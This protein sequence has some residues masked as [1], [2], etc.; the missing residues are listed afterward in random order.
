MNEDVSLHFNY[1][2]VAPASSK[3]RSGES[4]ETFEEF[5]LHGEWSQESV[6]RGVKSWDDLQQQ[7]CGEGQG[8]CWMGCLDLPPGCSLENSVCLNNDDLP[9]CTETVTDNCENM[10]VSC[11]W[12]CDNNNFFWWR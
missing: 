2:Q 12:S 11:S 8:Y 1:L 4:D 9:C 10:D 3:P 7:Q 5:F 6:C